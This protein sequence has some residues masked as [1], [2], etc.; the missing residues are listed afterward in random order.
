MADRGAEATAF[1]D[2][3]EFEAFRRSVGMGLIYRGLES[4][5]QRA[6]TV[7][8]NRV[9]D[10]NIEVDTPADQEALEDALTYETATMG[11]SSYSR[12]LIRGRSQ[13]NVLHAMEGPGPARLDA[14]LMSRLATKMSIELDNQVFTQITGATYGGATGNGFV[15]PAVG[16]VFSGTNAYGIDRATGRYKEK[17][18]PQRSESEFYQ[19]VASM[20]GDAEFHWRNNDIMAG[21]LIGD[22]TPTGYAFVGP[23]VIVRPIVEWAKREGVLDMRMSVGTE[24]ARTSGILG[25]TA[26]AGTL[27][28]IDIVSTTALKPSGNSFTSVNGYFVPI[29]ASILGGIRP[30]MWDFARFGQGNTM[31]AAVARSTVIWPYF[32]GR[33]GQEYLGKVTVQAG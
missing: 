32:V 18:T 31:G 14:N 20:F 29:G 27:S 1:S 10:D 9:T 6:K 19:D 24:A 4:E 28:N 12:K 23:P 17:G 5:F 26:Y 2:L 33:H 15:V 30:M 7:T 3:I 25:T 22:A 16:A 21:E 8:L 13:F 11:L